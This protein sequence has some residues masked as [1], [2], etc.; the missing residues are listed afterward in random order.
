MKHT[1]VE[2]IPIKDTTRL[3]A[4]KCPECGEKVDA[5]T[6]VSSMEMPSPG[7]V[8]LCLYCGALL[9]Y[10]ALLHSV[11]MRDATRRDMIANQPDEWEYML[12]MQAKFRST[13]EK[14][15]IPNTK[16]KVQ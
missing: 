6:H 3:P 16:P 10:D 5:A 11:P 7:D 12:T 15:V 9:E 13:V 4:S 14:F 1:K 8:S 2:L